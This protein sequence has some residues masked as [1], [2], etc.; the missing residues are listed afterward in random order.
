[1]LSE[2][3]SGI[4]T[5]SQE[6]ETSEWSCDPELGQESS[7]QNSMLGGQDRPSYVLGTEIIP[8]WL[9]HGL[10]ESKVMVEVAETGR[11]QDCGGLSKPC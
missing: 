8:A 4:Q 1:M 7:K 5:Q 9:E 6:E 2:C 3:K 10:R 11:G